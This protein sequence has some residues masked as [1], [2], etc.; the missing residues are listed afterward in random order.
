MKVSRHRSGAFNLIELLMVIAIIAIL[1][2]L[3]LPALSQ[4]KTRAIRLQCV[5][6]LHQ[7]GIAFQSFAH[8]HNGQYPMTVPMSAGGSMEFV[9]NAY[10]ITGEFYFGFRHF[11]ALSN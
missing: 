7:A 9:Q 8:D 4:A 2:A 11:Q 10:L 1:A 6:H 5:N 3:L